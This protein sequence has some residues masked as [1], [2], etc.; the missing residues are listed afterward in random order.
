MNMN[1]KDIFREIE[2][3]CRQVKNSVYTLD[4][5]QRKKLAKLWRQ[6]IQALPEEERNDRIGILGYG[7]VD[8]NKI[9]ELIEKDDEFFHLIVEVFS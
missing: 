5:E 2:A 6:Y 4:V 3:F 7:I 8:L 1:A 9:P